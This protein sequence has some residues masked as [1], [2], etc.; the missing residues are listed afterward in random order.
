MKIG[1]ERLVSSQRW[2]VGAQRRVDQI[3]ALSNQ[4]LKRHPEV[5]MLELGLE[6]WGEKGKSSCREPAG[7]RWKGARGCGLLSAVLVHQL[8]Y[9]T[10]DD[11]ECGGW[12]LRRG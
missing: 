7:Q 10:Q 2:K 9:G 12:Y 11:F 3:V 1:E 4:W 5:V 6:E 8:G